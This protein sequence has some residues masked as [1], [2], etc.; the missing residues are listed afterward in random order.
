MSTQLTVTINE[1]K[2]PS[3]EYQGQRVV[4]LKEIDTVH[5]RPDGTARRNLN[6]NKEHF[7]EGTDFFVLD[8]PDEIRTLGFERPQGG[9]SREPICFPK[10]PSCTA[11]AL[12][13]CCGRTV[14]A[15]TTTK[16][17]RRLHK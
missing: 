3:K 15:Q 4:T 13:N 16:V 11:A 6:A 12:T 1:T 14:P 2:L 8:Q 17:E 7:I 5:N 10:S 9:T